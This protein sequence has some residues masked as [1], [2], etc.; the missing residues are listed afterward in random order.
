MEKQAQLFAGAL[1]AP[2]RT[3][4]AVAD[5]CVK[6]VRDAGLELTA[7][8]ELDWP[9]V[10]KGIADKLEVNEMTVKI[11]FDDLGLIYRYV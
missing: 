2:A 1:L 10:W 5:E 6:L 8:P 4:T 11:R 9:Y 7:N 3:I